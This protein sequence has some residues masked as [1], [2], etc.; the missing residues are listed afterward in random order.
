MNGK[1]SQKIIIAIRLQKKWQYFLLKRLSV[2]IFQEKLRSIIQIN[3]KKKPILFGTYILL[4]LLT[5]YL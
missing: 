3:F 4:L 1:N 5:L 2:K